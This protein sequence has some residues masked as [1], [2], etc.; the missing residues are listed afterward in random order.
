MYTM[1]LVLHVNWLLMVYFLPVVLLVKVLV[2][3][4]RLWHYMS[5]RQAHKLG[6]G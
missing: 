1:F 5:A 6:R 4:I 3:F 2:R